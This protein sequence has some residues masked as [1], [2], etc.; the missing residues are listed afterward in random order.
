MILTNQPF[1]S[2]MHEREILLRISNL[3]KVREDMMKISLK[4]DTYLFSR[5]NFQ[6]LFFLEELPKCS[7]AC[8]T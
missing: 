6:V 3:R 4:S 8:A 7:A 2:V 5:K 1:L